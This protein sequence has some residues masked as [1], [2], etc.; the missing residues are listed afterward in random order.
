MNKAILLGNVGADPQEHTFAN[1]AKIASFSL[2]TS[3][4]YKD[5]TGNI[6]EQTSWHKVKFSGDQADKVMRLVKKSAY[7]QVDGSIRYDSFTNKEGVEVHTTTIQ[8][9]T[10]RIIAFPKRPDGEAVKEDAEEDYLRAEVG[11]RATEKL[12]DEENDEFSRFQKVHQAHV[13]YLPLAQSSVLLAGL[14]YPKLSA[15]AGAAYI[16]GRFVYSFAYIRS[17]PE[18]RKWGVCLI[19][20]AIV[21]LLGASFYGSFK[22]LALV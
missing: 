13:E 7:V 14:F 6:I 2:A 4:R 19:C 5:G 9:E 20:P 16:A 3:R 8:G 11:S 10:I 17:G 12:S 1:G 21:T 15:Y 18:A 22:A